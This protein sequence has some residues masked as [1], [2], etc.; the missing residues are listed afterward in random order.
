MTTRVLTLLQEYVTSLT[1]S[2]TTML[3]FIEKLSTLNAIKS[4]FRSRMIK[5]TC[6]AY[7]Q[8]GWLSQDNQYEISETASYNPTLK[9]YPKFLAADTRAPSSGDCA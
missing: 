4:Y 9:T 3:I 1:K 7:S 2:V 5:H 6:V 8:S